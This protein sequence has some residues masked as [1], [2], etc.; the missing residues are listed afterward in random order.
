MKFHHFTERGTAYFPNFL[1]QFTILD[2]ID[3]G[4][5]RLVPIRNYKGFLL[6]FQTPRITKKLNL[7]NNVN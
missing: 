1:E 6:K 2:F 7:T 5:E 3:D 4:S